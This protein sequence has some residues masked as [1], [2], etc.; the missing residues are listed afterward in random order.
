M[1]TED[2]MRMI[3]QMRADAFY[4]EQHFGRFIASYKKQF[5]EKEFLRLQSSQGSAVNIVACSAQ[6]GERSSSVPCVVGCLE[7]DIVRGQNSVALI[8]NVVVIPEYRRQGI[9]QKML[10]YAEDEAETMG[11]VLLRVDVELANTSAVS[12]YEGF[13]FDRMSDD[14]ESWTE[15]QTRVGRIVTLSKKMIH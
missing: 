8:K 15:S 4:E 1:D 9:A 3:S 12:L 10:K 6:V 13:G 2:D 5:A 11:A 14:D 7:M